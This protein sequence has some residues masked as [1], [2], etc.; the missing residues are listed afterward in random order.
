MRLA[1]EESIGRFRCAIRDR[2]TAVATVCCAVHSRC[3][4]SLFTLHSSLSSTVCCVQF[5]NTVPLHFS[6][7]TLLCLLLPTVSPA[8]AGDGGDK[9][10]GFDGLGQMQ[11]ITGG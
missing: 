7:F 9:V 4:S 11:L 2:V 5:T 10:G 6:L 1:K 8:Q 3:S